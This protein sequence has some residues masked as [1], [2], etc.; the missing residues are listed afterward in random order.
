MLA[1]ESWPASGEATAGLVLRSGTPAGQCRTAASC[2]VSTPGPGSSVTGVTG[3]TRR[4]RR[5]PVAPADQQ[6]DGGHVGDDREGEQLSDRDVLPPGYL[7]VGRIDRLMGCMPWMAS[8]WARSR[9]LQPG[10]SRSSRMRAYGRA[11]ADASRGWRTGDGR[12]E[13]NRLHRPHWAHE[14][15]RRETA[16]SS[17]TMSARITLRPR[18]ALVRTGIL[19]STQGGISLAKSDA[20]KGC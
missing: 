15:M 16:W 9:A 17:P 12:C 14:W 11:P 1:R 2:R 18:R 19:S 3:V 20:Y 13:A 7:Q 10:R 8:R 4:A 6:V 5:S